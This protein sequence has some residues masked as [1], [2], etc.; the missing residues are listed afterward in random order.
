MTAQQLPLGLSKASLVRLGA[1]AL[2]LSLLLYAGV[3][4]PAVAMLAV[5]L[6][7][8]SVFRDKLWNKTQGAVDKHSRLATLPAWA[9]WL[10]VLMAVLVVYYV[11]KFLVFAALKTA[12]YDV[13]SQLLAALNATANS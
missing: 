2:L 10:L 11:L 7:T 9:R 3:P 8:L 12:G 4:W 5:V 13:E 1:L 6:G